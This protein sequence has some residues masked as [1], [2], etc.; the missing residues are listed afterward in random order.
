MGTVA[1][2]QSVRQMIAR[3]GLRRGNVVTLKVSTEIRASDQVVCNSALQQIAIAYFGFN[4]FACLQGFLN[5][6]FH[7]PD[8]G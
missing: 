7:S 8:K 2:N 4:C 3:T 6:V 1:K 5:A